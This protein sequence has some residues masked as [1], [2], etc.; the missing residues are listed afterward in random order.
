LAPLKWPFAALS[1]V[2]FVSG[3]AFSTVFRSTMAKA[4]STPSAPAMKVSTIAG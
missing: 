4:T 1:Q 2:R 3:W